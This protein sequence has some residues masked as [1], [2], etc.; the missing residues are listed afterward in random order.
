MILKRL[1]LVSSLAIAAPLLFSA[2]SAHADFIGG[3]V[4][5]SYWNAGYGG[6]VTDRAGAP[7]MIDLERDL[8]FD[9]SSVVEFSAAIEHPVPVL[10][11]VKLKHIDLSDTADGSVSVTFDG[12]AFGGDV[13]TDL[14]LTHSSAVLYYE[15]LDNI[16][17][18]D[19]GIEAKLFDGKL[20]IQ[21][22]TTPSNVTETKI[23]D[24]I[25]MA[26]LAASADLPFTGLSV[27]AEVSGI[28]YSGD[29]IMDAKA[30]VRYGIGLFFL[31]GG[32]R[33]MTIKVEDVNDIDVD[34]DL[35]GAYL[36]AGVDF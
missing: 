21:D 14:D 10:P 27:G 36:S 3:E 8:K 11:N 9:D 25:P 34:A 28:G 5:V 2:T 20:R 15:V 1:S 12:V 4:S 31:E 7:Q 17:S 29:K 6:S 24:P 19:V 30:K 33:S 23:D 16:V 32:Y 35:S 22:K 18:V 13:K 26:Y